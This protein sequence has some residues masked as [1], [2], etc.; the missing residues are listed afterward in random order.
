MDIADDVIYVLL[1]KYIY[2]GIFN[3]SGP[4]KLLVIWLL[5]IP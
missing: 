2:L 1:S 3:I 5:T 4:N